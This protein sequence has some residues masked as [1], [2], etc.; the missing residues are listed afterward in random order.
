MKLYYSIS[1]VAAELGVSQSML[2]FWE[3]EFPELRPAKNA[4]G[5]RMYRQEDIDLLRR[6][7]FLTKE[8]GFTLDGAREQL[9]KG[10]DDEMHIIDTLKQTRE[11][12]VN[13]KAQL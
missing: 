1:E 5:V 4:R 11:F 2:R 6:I 10:S 13:L 3:S 9:H 8:C 7:I 12:L